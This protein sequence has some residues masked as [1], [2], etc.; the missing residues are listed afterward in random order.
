MVS[1]LSKSPVPRAMRPGGFL[2]LTS[3][4]WAP[5]K[6]KIFAWLV[7]Q[8]RIPTADILTVRHAK[9]IMVLSLCCKPRNS[10][11][12]VYQLCLHKEG[13]ECYSIL[14]KSYQHFANARGHSGIGF[15][16]V[17]TNVGKGS[18][19]E[20]KG[21]KFLNYTH[22]TNLER[23]EQTNFSGTKDGGFRAGSNGQRRSLS[24]DP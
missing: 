21:P 22:L 18:S 17:G 8:E 19:D 23:N 10:K 2:W 24:L 11:T 6:C 3:A 20:Q 7:V 16:M 9:R 5:Q 4:A 1:N 15:A 14:V 12:P 13:V